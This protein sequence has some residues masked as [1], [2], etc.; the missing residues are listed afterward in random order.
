MDSA[1]CCKVLIPVAGLYVWPLNHERR[2]A[3]RNIMMLKSLGSD[4]NLER[5]RV[6]DFVGHSS[7]LG[8]SGKRIL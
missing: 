6:E 1:W 8:V 7:G 4:F 3:A 2:L 5:M